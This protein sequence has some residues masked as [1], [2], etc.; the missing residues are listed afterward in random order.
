V[1]FDR[2]DSEVGLQVRRGVVKWAVF[3]ECEGEKVVDE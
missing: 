3:A 2:L 1:K